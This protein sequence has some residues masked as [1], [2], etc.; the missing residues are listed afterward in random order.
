MGTEEDKEFPG[1][2][3]Q[4]SFLKFHHCWLY[5]RTTIS[6]QARGLDGLAMDRCL[7]AGTIPLESQKIHI[8]PQPLTPSSRLLLH[9][10]I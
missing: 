2:L 7:E 5:L 10:R 8:P 4:L 9:S 6:D 1:K 3:I